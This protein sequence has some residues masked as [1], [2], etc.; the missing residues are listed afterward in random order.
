MLFAPL[1]ATLSSQITETAELN[2][3]W[4]VV[5]ARQT[6]TVFGNRQAKTCG[7]TLDKQGFFAFGRPAMLQVHRC[8]AAW[9]L[10]A[11]APYA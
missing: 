7:L 1:S 6:G 2:D 3:N 9:G 5:G 8:S 11:K 4:V 10:V